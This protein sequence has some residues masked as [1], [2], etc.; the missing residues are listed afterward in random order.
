MCSLLHFEDL[1]I[2]YI[3]ELLGFKNIPSFYRVFEKYIGK[4]PIEYRE[5]NIVDNKRFFAMK[6]LYLKVIQYI[7]LHISQ[8]F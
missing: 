1:S 3:T 7:Y 2:S 5:D 6:D 4:S 8:L